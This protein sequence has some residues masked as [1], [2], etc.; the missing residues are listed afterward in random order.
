M[1]YAAE[2]EDNTVSRNNT[3]LKGLIAS[4]PIVIGYVPVAMTFGAACIGTGLEVWQAVVMSAFMY[5]GASQFIVLGAIKTGTGMGYIMILCAAISCRH[6]LYGPLIVNLWPR[7]RKS[8]ILAA[9][10]LTDEVFAV[11]L[12]HLNR[13]RVQKITQQES[14]KWYRGLAF[15]AYAAWVGGTAI[16]AFLGASLGDSSP[17]VEGALRFAFPAMFLALMLQ[18]I[19]PGTRRAVFAAACVAGLMAYLEYSALAIAAGAFVGV[20]IPNKERG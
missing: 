15:A 4:I 5:S 17:I 16:G 11:S 2:A 19:S 7:V 12:T 8:R 3:V 13:M 20:A 18:S 9:L 1:D 6:L 10:G 14:G